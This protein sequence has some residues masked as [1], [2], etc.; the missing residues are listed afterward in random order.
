MLLYRKKVKQWIFQ[1]LLLSDIKVGRCSQ[2]TEYMNLYEYQ[3]SRSFIG[4]G[5]NLS[6]SIFLNLFSS[7]STRLIE[8]KFH[9][10]P[11]WNGGTKVSSNGPGHMTKMTAML[12]YGKNL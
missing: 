12:I 10:K 4:L 7:V 5:P 8:V 11:P 6:D 9:V 1:K 3:R 2:P